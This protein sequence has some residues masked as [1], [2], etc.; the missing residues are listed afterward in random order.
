MI[1]SNDECAI[2]AYSLGYYHALKGIPASATADRFYA[3]G[4]RTG[5]DLFEALNQ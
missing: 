3:L 4:H 5:A 2:W 1:K